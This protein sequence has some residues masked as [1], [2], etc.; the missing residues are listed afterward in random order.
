MCTQFYIFCGKQEKKKT[1][2]VFC[3]AIVCLCLQYFFFVVA[4]SVIS[5][6]DVSTETG[7]VVIGT[8]DN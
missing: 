5:L 6:F 3:T 1:D 4:H 8:T 7:D 2:I